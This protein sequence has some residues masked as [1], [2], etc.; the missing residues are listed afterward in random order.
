MS[1]TEIFRYRRR[2]PKELRRHFAKSEIKISLGKNQ[3]DALRKYAAIEKWYAD[4][5][6][7]SQ[8]EGPTSNRELAIW[9]LEEFSAS[10]YE[11]GRFDE[12]NVE[13]LEDAIDALVGK[14]GDRYESEED[15]GLRHKMPLEVIQ[16]LAKGKIPKET[17]TISSALKFY[18]DQKETGINHKDRAL[19]RRVELLEERLISALGVHRVRVRSLEDFTRRDARKSVDHLQPLMK[20]NSVKR[21]I[22]ILSA[23]VNLTILEHDL[24][25]GNRF[26][27]LEIKGAG[28]HKDQRAPLSE[29]DMALLEKVMLK[30]D[31]DIL[32]A[33]WI[34]LSDTGARLGEVCNLRVC[35]VNPQ[36]KC[37]HISPHN[38][39][40]LKTKS[41]ERTVPL[42]DGVLEK[43]RLHRAG[44]EHDEL[45]FPRYAGGRGPDSASGA[46][47][48]RFRTVVSDPKKSAAH[49]LR[50]RMKDLLRNS[51]CPD[52]LSKEILG[53]SDQSISANYGSGTALEMKRQALEKVWS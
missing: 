5:V 29:Q 20:P 37:M 41:S 32:G 15:Q 28:S 2:V 8:S 7:K 35:D 49:S 27:K 36:L 24:D 26:E 40:T 30:S 14:L 13:G 39:H 25:C 3:V 22:Q 47:A 38:D 16:T 11:L 52:S 50:H 53:H 12:G 46:L 6:K 48:K 45:I 34:T 21:S 23:A 9:A 43:L 33:I 44:K 10:D 17:H 51:G 31:G 42:S 18:L 19:A 4:E 1:A